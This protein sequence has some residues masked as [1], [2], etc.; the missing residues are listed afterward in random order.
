LF[1]QKYKKKKRKQK[2]NKIYPLSAMEMLGDNFVIGKD[3]LSLGKANLLEKRAR[4]F[5]EEFK[6]SFSTLPFLADFMFK[7]WWESVESKGGSS[8]KS[9]KQAQKRRSP[10]WEPAEEELFLSL[11]KQ[12][13]IKSFHRIAEYFPVFP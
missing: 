8:K 1:S 2:S 11:I 12:N 10:E 13:E 5:S 4:N 9:Q 6:D 3:S 7:F